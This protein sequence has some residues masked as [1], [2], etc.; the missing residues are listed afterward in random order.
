MD[1]KDKVTP[2][3]ILLLPVLIVVFRKPIDRLLL[4]LQKLKNQAPRLVLIGVGLATPYMLAH[5]YIK[6]G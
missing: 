4:P 5:Y 1:V 6:M 2:F 3:Y